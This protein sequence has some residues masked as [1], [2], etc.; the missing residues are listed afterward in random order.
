MSLTTEFDVATRES[1]S[2]YVMFRD[3][4]QFL[5]LRVDRYRG[6]AGLDGY[7]VPGFRVRARIKPHVRDPTGLVITLA[8]RQKTVCGGCGKLHLRF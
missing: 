6:F 8:R 7:R 1:W 4:K 5:L 2:R 3:M